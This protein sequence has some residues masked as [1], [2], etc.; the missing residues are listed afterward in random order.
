[1]EALLLQ[2]LSGLATGGIYASL[3]LAVVMIYKAT[4]VVNFAQGEMAM[5]STYLAWQFIQWG[6]PYWGAFFLTIAVSFVGGVLIERI[7]IRPF[8]AHDAVL[9]VVTVFIGLF[10]ILN[11]LAGWTWEY[12]LKS[13]PSPFPA[14]AYLGGYLSGHQL[15]LFFVVLATL[16]VVYAFFRFTPLGL[17]MRAA[18]ENPDSSRLVGI[19][20]SWM[21]AL[22]WG[23]AAAL[24]AIAGIMV[25]P[26]VF[27]EPNMMGFVLIYAFAG[28]LLGG[29]DN[30]WGAVIGGF[31]MGVL[32]NIMGVY[33]VGTELKL[34]VALVIIVGV[35]V[36]RPSGIFGSAVV[37]R[38]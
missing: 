6:L 26:L 15:G 14:E 24:G 17:A 22:G 3:A 35:L 8:E 16:A 27:L 13:F 1:M 33:V 18:A 20:V 2:V 4:H 31:T 36:V 25:A 38:V 11:S 37:T 21:L 23:F 5:F 32:E 29:I 34:T 7:V 28:A 10:L 9:A 12:T 30:P 19:R